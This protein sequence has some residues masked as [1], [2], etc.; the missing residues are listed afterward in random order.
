MISQEAGDL[1]L[2]R[3]SKARE[4]LR[5]AKLL[6]DNGDYADSVNRSYYAVFTAARALLA[7]KGLD[8]KKH[9][10]VISLFSQH[11]VKTGVIGKEA[12]GTLL[13][14]KSFRE[15]ADYADY[16]EITAEVAGKELEKAGELVDEVERKLAELTGGH[17]DF[18]R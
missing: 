8:S 11:F 2:Y 15:D 7:L 6:F 16:V 3:L 18:K 17:P 12:G 14:S 4:R 5:A 9:S 13:T 1:A 10:G